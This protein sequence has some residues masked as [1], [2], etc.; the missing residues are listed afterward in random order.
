MKIAIELSEDELDI[1]RQCVKSSLG[2]NVQYRGM[3]RT[4]H[5]RSR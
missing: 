1:L 2:I 3:L 5:T 4:S